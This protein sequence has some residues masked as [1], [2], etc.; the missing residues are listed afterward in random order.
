LY[1]NEI[2]K[3]T[4][5][6][7]KFK[8]FHAAT[9]APWPQSYDAVANG[10]CDFGVGATVFVVN[11]MPITMGL[12]LPFVTDSA[13][14]A[15]LVAWEMYNT[16]PEMKKEYKKVKV[17]GLYSTANGNLHSL[18]PTYKT[19]NDLKAARIGASAPNVVQAM[20][21]LGASAQPIKPQDL[22]MALQRKMI[23]GIIFPDAPMRSMK[24]TDLLS[25]HT[26]VNLVNA[27]FGLFMNKQAWDKLP[28][29][30]QKVFEEMSQSAG[31]LCGETLINEAAWI[32][33]E[34]KKRGD[35]FYYLPP[36]EKAKWKAAIKPMY[37]GW[38]KRLNK[39]GMNGQAIFDQM[40]AIAEKYRNKPYGTDGWWG[41]A[42]KKR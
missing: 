23:D 40:M 21:L 14:H 2:E 17:L 9:I 22:Y 34:L 38:I 29:D 26:I 16:I 7:V 25:N 13:K 15:S 1:G 12:N 27:T 36:A 20:K 4:H 31:A 41:N 10:L 32:N 37:Q 6:K 39:N 3:R 33:D 42:G 24:L 8:W 28:A 18:L 30:V 5:G 11:K 19:L 35:K